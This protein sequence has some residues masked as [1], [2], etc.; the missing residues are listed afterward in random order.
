MHYTHY[1]AEGNQ[2]GLEGNDP[3]ISMFIHL[4]YVNDFKRQ[5]KEWK[6]FIVVHICK[7]G[8]V[9][10][11]YVRGRLYYGYAFERASAH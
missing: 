2:R 6:Q 5:I 10:L 9:G 1:F 3:M 4:Q 7:N 11:V 8:R